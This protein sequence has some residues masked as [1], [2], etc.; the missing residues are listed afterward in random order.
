M[1]YIEYPTRFPP[2]VQSIGYQT[3]KPSVPVVVRPFPNCVNTWY[4]NFFPA[5][6][7]SR[8]DIPMLPTQTN[9]SCQANMETQPKSN[10]A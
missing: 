4:H 6:T 7:S 1:Q 10:V 9:G 5:G 8:Q 3:V 2:V